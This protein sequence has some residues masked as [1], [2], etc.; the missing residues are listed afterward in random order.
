LARASLLFAGI[1]GRYVKRMEVKTTRDAKITIT[2][3][4]GT[5]FTVKAYLYGN[6]FDAETIELLGELERAGEEWARKRRVHK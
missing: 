3:P 6:T 2:M 4:S 1:C 5:P